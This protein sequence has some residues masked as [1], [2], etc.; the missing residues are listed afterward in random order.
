MFLKLSWNM[1][2]QLNARTKPSKESGAPGGENV[3]ARG[4]KET[5]GDEGGTGGDI[6]TDP[7][8]S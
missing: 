7:V 6:S 8:V 2:Q 4:G 1:L 5:I 3:G